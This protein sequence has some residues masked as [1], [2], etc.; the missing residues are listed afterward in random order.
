MIP[1]CSSFGTIRPLL[2]RYVA[3]LYASG[4]SQK[5]PPHRDHLS[6]VQVSSFTPVGEIAIRYLPGPDGFPV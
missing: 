5:A 3:D 2:G 6:G 4:G 1:T